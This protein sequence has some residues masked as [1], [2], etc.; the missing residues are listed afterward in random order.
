V[1]DVYKGLTIRF[2][3]ETTALTA[4]LKGID[5]Q[6]RAIGTELKKVE[7]AL[8]F[9]PGNSELIRQKQQLLAKQIDTTRERLEALKQAQSKMGDADINTDAYNNLQREIIV[10]ESKL[11]SYQGKLAKVE[12]AQDTA[13][14]SAGKYAAEVQE[15]G[16]KV[17]AAGDK[18]SSAGGKISGA[19]NSLTMGVT[20]PALAAGAA[21]FTLAGNFEQSMNMVA[22][23]TGAPKEDMDDLIEL[24]KQL[25]AE[26]VF[27]SQDAAGAMLELAKSGLTPAE[28]KAGALAAALQLAS[29]G[30]LDLATAS[31]VMANA[32]NTFGLKAEDAESVAAALAGGANASSASVDSLQQALAQAGAGSVNAGLSLQQTVG[33]LAAFADQGIQG[34]DAGTSLKTML[35]RLIPATDDAAMALEKYNLTFVDANGNIDDITV[36]AQKLQDQLGGLSEAERNAALQQ[37]FG[38]D[39]TRAASI[40]MRDGAAVTQKY[41][42]ATED[43]AAAQK[44]ADAA[45]SG[46]KGTIEEMTGSIET[47]AI[48]AGDSLAPVVTDLAKEITDL[49]N[50]FGEL[51]K[52]DQQFILKAIA[53]AAAVGPVIKGVGTLTT[54]VGALTKGYGAASAG[55]A[56]WAAKV[57]AS[58]VASASAVATSSALTGVIAA[59]GP[60]AGVAA[61]VGIAALTAKVLS[62]NSPLE[63]AKRA[64]DDTL[65]S[66]VSFADTVVEKTGEVGDV[67]AANGESIVSINQRIADAESAIATAL[68][69]AVR[70][71]G[72]LRSEDI[73]NVQ[74]YYDDIAALSKQK[75]DAFLTSIAATG[76]E[77]TALQGQLSKDDA[78]QYVADINEKF[79]GAKTAY[80]EGHAS[81]LEL[82]NEKYRAA[83][84]IGSAA[85][86]IEIRAE[87]ARYQEQLVAAQQAANDQIAVVQQQYA[88]Q[89]GLTTNGWDAA[90]QAAK[91]GAG[92][93]TQETRAAIAGGN[94]DVAQASHQAAVEAATKYIEGLGNIDQ[95]TTDAWLSAAAATVAGGGVVVGGVADA[96]DM[97]LDTLAGYPPGAEDQAKAAAQKMAAGLVGTIPELK[98]ASKMTTEE[99]VAAIRDGLLTNGQTKAAGQAASQAL[100][101]GLVA[102]GYTVQEAAAMV[103]GLASGEITNQWGD[104]YSWGKH[105]VEGMARGI[106]EHSRIL[107][108]AAEGAAWKVSQYLEFT[109]PDL[110][111]LHDYEEW[112]PHMVQG[113]SRTLEASTPTLEKAASST[114]GA[115]AAAVKGA[116]GGL[117][118]LIGNHGAVAAVASPSQGGQAAT[119]SAPSSIT[120]SHAINVTFVTPVTS[121]SDTVRGVR[122]AQRAAARG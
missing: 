49:A 11:E 110:G 47:A 53:T 122:D 42:T 83:G 102:D 19:G 54:G 68:G 16:E 2:G 89:L 24:A 64:L 76:Y 60:I 15:S 78:A 103:A 40:L 10:T 101:R 29:A 5:K 84:T 45:M 121:Y 36:V 73:A 97:M 119:A 104:S 43:Q 111:P 80:S 117:G 18:I 55:A 112:M 41:I 98:N 113:L 120:D 93:M 94:K 50:E 22:Q 25:G 106:N 9:S 8:D 87:N 92:I 27:S 91:E 37:I 75:G 35:A 21:A 4:A 109:R 56:K 66:Y 33:V 44:M 65:E 26:T 77:A 59:I 12:A 31:T 38:S 105:M 85:Y 23:A 79:K 99:I 7:R 14:V 82:I 116:S 34:S 108:Q 63:K 48:T 71:N 57:A 86:G 88:G 95:A 74:K 96:V 118:S 46:S 28:I 114:A 52:E 70:K 32:I 17:K 115:I 51:S 61:V 62:M 107:V 81:E 30:G 39:A 67:T 72:A 90:A 100:A 69:E 6:S 20:L 13:R 1:A 58:E 3:A